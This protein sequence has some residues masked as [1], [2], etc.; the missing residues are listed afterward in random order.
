M[1]E[2]LKTQYR[3]CWGT[4][5]FL[6]SSLAFF[7]TFCVSI[8]LT[9]LANAY[10]TARASNSVTDI[11][12]SN[13]PALDVDDYFVYGSALLAVFVIGLIIIYPKRLPF[14]LFSM[15]LFYTIRAFFITLTHLAPFPT[16]TP[17]DFTTNFGLFLARFFFATGDDLFFSAHAGAPFLLALIFWD[18][19]LLRYFFLGWSAFFAVIV[20]LGHIHYSIDV[21]SAYFI[22][23]TIYIIARK[24][25]TWELFRPLGLL[26]GTK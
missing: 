9:Y 24:L 19:R 20:L 8:G 3:D 16:H 21:A 14:V 2:H 11:I 10:A 1:K 12:L 7:I 25:S 18:Q 4:E 13:V 15:S 23:Y 17:I 22:T 6:V 5:R 26:E